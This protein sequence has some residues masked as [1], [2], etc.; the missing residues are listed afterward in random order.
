MGGAYVEIRGD[1]KQV[2]TE[3]DKTQ[4]QLNKFKAEAARIAEGLVTPLEKL[5][6]E[7]AKIQVLGAKGYLSPEQTDRGIAQIKKQF[8]ELTK[9]PSFLDSIKSKF[10]AKG[11]LKDVLEPL[12]VGGGAIAGITF[13]AAQFDKLT[14]SV[15]DSAN[16]FRL[17]KISFGGLVKDFAES[18]PILGSVV[19]GFR[20]IGEAW[21]GTEAIKA[22]EEKY[23][24]DSRKAMEESNAVRSVNS[25]R[26]NLRGFLSESEARARASESTLGIRGMSMMDRISVTAG[27]SYNEKIQDALKIQA[28]MVQQLKDA[29]KKKLDDL[30]KIES[31]L[32]ADQFAKADAY[33]KRV[34]IEKGLIDDEARVRMA[35]A[36]EIAS[37]RRGREQAIADAQLEYAKKFAG[38]FMKRTFE[39]DG[40]TGAIKVGNVSITPGNG[41]G[42]FSGTLK[43][44]I[45]GQVGNVNALMNNARGSVNLQSQFSGYGNE[46]GGIISA[47]GDI[48]TT[49]KDILQA[50][51]KIADKPSPSFT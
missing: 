2:V 14:G 40:K 32:K 35:I 11:S 15:A 42:N 1:G 46:V 30:D 47:S 22:R 38:D 48:G 6:V 37:H 3:L 24:A 44:W 16:K 21:V 29:A 10:G 19:R 12:L 50:V 5:E 41:D 34:E 8:D 28:E 33:K 26:A 20:N 4:A 23:A 31:D 13:A 39:T 9:G 25:G 45:T 36:E 49:T 43:D 51:I 17:G 18:I 7:L 27:G